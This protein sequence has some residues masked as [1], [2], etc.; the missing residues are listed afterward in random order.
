[1]QIIKSSILFIVIVTT[2][3]LGTAMPFFIK[4]NLNKITIKPH[5]YHANHPT[6]RDSLAENA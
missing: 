6:V 4:F 1:M 5:K 3:I 2:V